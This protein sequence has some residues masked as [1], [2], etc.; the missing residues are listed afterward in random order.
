MPMPPVRPITFIGAPSSKHGALQR[1]V[2]H[3]GC[4]AEPG[5]EARG[6][7]GGAACRCRPPLCAARARRHRGQQWGDERGVDDV[8]DDQGGGGVVEIELERGLALT[9]RA[10]V[11]FTS[12][13]WS[14]RAA[15]RMVR[16]GDGSS[17]QG[18]AAA[19]APGR[20]PRASGWPDAHRICPASSR[21]AAMA[22]AP[23]PAPSRSGGAAAGS[24]PCAATRLAMKPVAVGVAC[25]AMPPGPKTM[26]VHGPGA[27][28]PDGSTRSSHSARAASLCGTVR[29]QPRRTAGRLEA[30]DGGRGEVLGGDGERARR[31]RRCR[32]ALEPVA[33]QAGASASARTGQPTTPASAGLLPISVRVI[34]SS[35]L[36]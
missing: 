4:D 1:R 3:R 16:P 12:S 6:R 36:L 19:P 15:S 10:E 29:L 22:R 21:A 8:G 17:C 25:Q 34:A 33:V 2:V 18:S 5:G 11:V 23:P 13:A 31:R 28:V 9:S 20:A 32:A 35:S 14:G 7:P 24:G 26:R 30:V 27:G